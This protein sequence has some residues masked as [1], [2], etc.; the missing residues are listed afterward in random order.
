MYHARH[1]AREVHNRG[2]EAGLAAGGGGRGSSGAAVRRRGAQAIP[3][4]VL[5]AAACPACRGLRAH[6]HRLLGLIRWQRVVCT[7]WRGPP[8]QPT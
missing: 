1:A 2:A 7:A 5:P 4:V 8:S 6:L 3:T